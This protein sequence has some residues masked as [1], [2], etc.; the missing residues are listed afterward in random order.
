MP[1]FDF[2]NATPGNNPPKSVGGNQCLLE[3]GEQRSLFKY[4]GTSVVPSSSYDSGR[5]IFYETPFTTEENRI[6]WI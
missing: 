2:D 4:S 1:A 5:W 6:Y 3:N